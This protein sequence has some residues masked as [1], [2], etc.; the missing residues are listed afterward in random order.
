MIRSPSQ[1]DQKLDACADAAAWRTVFM[2]YKRK[3]F[4]ACKRKYSGTVNSKRATPKPC[5][6][7]DLRLEGLCQG[8]QEGDHRSTSDMFL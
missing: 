1:S 7:V 3:Y 2:A 8:C 6:M 5:Y 4:I